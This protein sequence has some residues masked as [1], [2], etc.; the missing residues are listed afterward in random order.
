LWRKFSW[1]YW[2]LPVALCYCGVLLIKCR[3]GP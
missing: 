2:N 3:Q 1:S